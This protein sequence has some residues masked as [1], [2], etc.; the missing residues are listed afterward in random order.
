[1]ADTTE[2]ANAN[3]SGGDGLNT[4]SGTGAEGTQTSQNNTN[5]EA[6]NGAITFS[7][8]QQAALEEII[9]KRLAKAKKSWQRSAAKPKAA[10]DEDVDVDEGSEE[11]DAAAEL[12]ALRRENQAFKDAKAQQ[13]RTEKVTELLSDRKYKV[14]NKAAVERHLREYLKFDKSNNPTNFEEALQKVHSFVPE[15]FG[16]G[17]GSINAGDG[18]NT[19]PGSDMNRLIRESFGF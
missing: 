8:E 1:M 11:N 19:Q 6:S 17:L 16:S 14:I 12:E 3:T 4:A 15:L 13:E 9:K 2:N 5:S 10:A 18:N 7:E